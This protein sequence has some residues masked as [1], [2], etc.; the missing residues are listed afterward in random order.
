V[1]SLPLNV[2]EEI[3]RYSMDYAWQWRMICK[4]INLKH[5]Y[6]FEPEDMEKLYRL[7]L[8]RIFE[9]PRTRVRA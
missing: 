9:R 5:G 2:L 1:E 6:N 8:G 7:N 4:I 3:R